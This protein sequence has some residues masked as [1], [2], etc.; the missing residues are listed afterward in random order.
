MD[1]SVRDMARALVRFNAAVIGIVLGLIAGAGLFLATAVLLIRGGEEPGPMLGLLRYF[2]P[3]YEVSWSGAFVGALW[4]LIAGAAIGVAV[5]LAYGP[6]LMEGAAR[7]LEVSGAGDEPDAHV[8]LLR[9]LPFALTS[10]GLLAGGLFLATNWLALR[11]W[12]SPTLALLHHYL[13]GYTATFAGSI[14]G[15]FWLLL[16]G[17]VAAGAAAAIYDRVALRRRAPGAGRR[18]PPQSSTT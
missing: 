11:G 13:P 5:G 1:A 18:V 2:F 9:P 16:Y 17:F 15:A 10:G 8:L 4:G 14:V 6:W 3:G 12:P 7:E